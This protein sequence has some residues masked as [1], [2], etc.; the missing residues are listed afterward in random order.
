MPNPNCKVT[1]Q[2]IEDAELVDIGQRMAKQDNRATQNVMFAVMVDV[3]VPAPDY[4]A[5]DQERKDS[6]YYDLDM[7]CEKC[8]DLHENGEELPDHCD[9][10]DPEC[11]WSY[12]VEQKL[13]VETCG[14]FFT[15]EA[16]QAHIDAN[17]YHY[18]NPRVYGIGSWRNPEMQLVQKHLIELANEKV[19]SHYL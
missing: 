8:A 1:K 12:R 15:A 17:H 13:E 11:F 7:L 2:I 6:D 10:C 18:S 9:D 14:V 19:P 16:C 5:E 3:K 4:L